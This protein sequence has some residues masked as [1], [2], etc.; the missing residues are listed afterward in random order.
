MRK[1]A[2][3][4]GSSSGTTEEIAGRIAGKL[5]VD[6]SNVYNVGEASVDDVASYD[7]LILGSSTW[8]VGDL[9]DDWEGFLPKLRKADLSGK[10]VAIFGTGDGSSFG[11]SFCD[12]IGTI[13]K[14]LQGSGGRFCGAVSKD[15]YSFD[16]STALVNGTFVGLPLD[17]V[18]EE[19]E[20]DGR[21]DRWIE[22]LKKEC[23]D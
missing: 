5:G 4:Y 19:R 20:T 9:Q 8:G 21:I 17:E 15:G 11:D 12:A 14:E 18:N 6:S 23:L 22:Q 16:D 13:Y 2:I 3:F 10:A 1:T 7:V